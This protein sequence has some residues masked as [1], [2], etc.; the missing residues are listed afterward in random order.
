M[1]QEDRS[2]THPI[3][4]GSIFDARQSYDIT[5]LAKRNTARNNR[6][7]GRVCIFITKKRGVI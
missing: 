2:K 3:A 4:L 6:I 1:N 7:S 5:R